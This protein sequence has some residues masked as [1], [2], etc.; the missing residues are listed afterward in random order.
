MDARR[1][2]RSIRVE[3]SLAGVAYAGLVVVAHPG[4]TAARLD[5]P[6]FP[7]AN[8][9]FNIG[10]VL[11]IAVLGCLAISLWGRLLASGRHRTVRGECRACTGTVMAEFALVL[12]IV[13]LV[14][15]MIIQLALIANASLVVRYAAFAAAR[16]AIVSFDSDMPG[17]NIASVIQFP[18][19][20]EWV[21]K[22]R[23][24][25]AAD[26][27]LASI[28]PRT[29][30]SNESAENMERLLQSQGGAWKNGN[31]ASRFKYAHAA[32]TVKTLRDDFGYFGGWYQ[33]FPPLIPR[34]EHLIA[35]YPYSQGDRTFYN[36]FLVPI[37]LIP[38]PLQI[39]PLSIAGITLPLPTSISLPSNIIDPINAGPNRVLSLLRS[40]SAAAVDLFADSVLNIDPM[41]PKEVKI[42]V[43]Y[44][45]LLTLPSLQFIP[46]LTKS[47]PVGTGTAFTIKHTVWLQSTGGR[48]GNVLAWFPIHKSLR[49]GGW[50]VNSPF[51]FELG[52]DKWW[53][54]FW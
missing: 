7:W 42:T 22:T 11:V 9:L 2:I 8:R 47:T 10:L 23:P 40:G 18:P 6:A 45:F 4:A 35:P 21:D 43:E 13:L 5:L 19:F 52:D 36:P 46:G 29:G 3:A 39:P 17:L 1:F 15:C 27:V 34:S 24:Q 14:M 33:S 28:S 16:S 41:S 54:K 38:N 53:K 51:P 44:D 49:K 32:T 50:K 37:Q 20:A 48:K 30:S 12:P 31:Y 26:L 25:L